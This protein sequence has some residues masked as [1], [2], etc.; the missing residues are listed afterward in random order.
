MEKKQQQ[1]QM[2]EN[3]VSGWLNSLS[4][5]LYGEG[6]VLYGGEKNKHFF[7]HTKK[8]TPPLPSEHRGWNT[9]IRVTADITA[10]T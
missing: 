4:V 3:K 5:I 1:Y 9:G 2:A 7:L 6:S 8:L 10:A